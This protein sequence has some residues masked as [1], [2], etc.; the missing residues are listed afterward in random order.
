[1]DYKQLALTV[2]PTLKYRCMSKHHFIYVHTLTQDYHYID[3]D[4]EISEA[5]MWR[6]LY[7][8]LIT[9][10]IYLGVYK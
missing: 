4:F 9:T 5:E 1:M 7:E 2:N 3:Y 6:R 10:D 8:A